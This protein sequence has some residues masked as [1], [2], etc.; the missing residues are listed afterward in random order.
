MLHVAYLVVE[1]QHLK[2]PP[3]FP[4]K[5]TIYTAVV[6]PRLW[7]Y[8]TCSLWCCWCQWS[9]NLGGIFLGQ[10]KAHATYFFSKGSNRSG[11]GQVKNPVGNAPVH[12]SVC[13]FNSLTAPV[14][15]CF[16]L[17]HDNP[18]WTGCLDSMSVQKNLMFLTREIGYP[19]TWWE[20]LEEPEGTGWNSWAS[21]AG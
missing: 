21:M 12:R 11:K 3:I 13:S 10:Q 6:Q 8:T 18:F 9:E 4:R 14:E 7:T 16:F 20:Q 2:M 5:E 1:K 19:S 15:R 17:G